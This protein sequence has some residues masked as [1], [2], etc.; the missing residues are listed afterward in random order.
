MHRR[1]ELV[2][3]ASGCALAATFDEAKQFVAERL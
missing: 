3:R 1:L 2:D